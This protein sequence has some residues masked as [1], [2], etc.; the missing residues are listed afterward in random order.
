MDR[1]PKGRG[2]GQTG[3]ET[4]TRTRE[5]SEYQ[6]PERSD[7]TGLKNSYRIFFPTRKLEVC[8]LSIQNNFRE[9]NN[10]ILDLIFPSPSFGF[11]QVKLCEQS[12]KALRISKFWRLLLDRGKHPWL[13]A[14]ALGL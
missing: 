12:G 10:W 6:M 13:V 4:G 14:S 7:K 3:K 9:W 11:Y 8:F 2:M 1:E 5:E